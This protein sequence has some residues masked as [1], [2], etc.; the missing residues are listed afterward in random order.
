MNSICKVLPAILVFNIAVW[1]STYYVDFSKGDDTNLGQG[2][3]SAWKHSPGDPNATDKPSQTI[4]N[5]GDTILFKGGVVYRGSIKLKANGVKGKEIV[6]AGDLWGEPPAIIDGSEVIKGWKQCLTEEQAKGNKAYKNLYRCR[7]PKPVTPYSTNIQYGNKFYFVAQY[8]SQPELFYYDNLANYLNQE[9][10]ADEFLVHSYLSSLNEDDLINNYVLTYE[11]N[12]VVKPR[13]ILKFIRNENKIFFEKISGTYYSGEKARF[14]LA[15]CVKFINKE[16]QF[17]FYY[18]S[19]D[20]CELF[21]WPYTEKPDSEHITYSNKRY[22]ISVTGCNHIIVQ[23][24]I[25]EKAA[26]YEMATGIGI[27]TV[28]TTPKISTSN[29]TIKNNIIRNISDASRG[30]YGGIYIGYAR[31]C[32]VDG[33]VITNGFNHRGI[34]FMGDTNCI[35]SNNK[36]IKPGGTGMTIRGSVNCAFIGNK[37]EDVKSGHAN[38]MTCYNSDSCFLINNDIE[39]PNYTMTVQVNKYLVIIG[40]VINAKGGLRCLVIYK[41]VDRAIIYHNTIVE[42]GNNVGIIVPKS[43]TNS[44]IA[45]NI[46]CGIVGIRNMRSEVK[47]EYNCYT[48]T[49]YDQDWKD[50]AGIGEIKPE[51]ADSIFKELSKKGY[52]LDSGDVCVDQGKD[53]TSLLP[54]ADK[55]PYFDFRIDKNGNMRG[56]DGKYDIGAVEFPGVPA[57]SKLKIKPAAGKM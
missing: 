29:I 11:G 49:G 34:L 37:V 5:A 8:P 44:H 38:G 48:A 12:N 14:A 18:E 46:I 21:I 1:A 23:G 25:V 16:G 47:L 7:V 32:L 42:S 28:G 10:M 35:A 30:G 9:Q 45:N 36:V 2:P 50:S 15:N 56:S 33:N 41:D 57:P 22:G 53:L 39:S 43:V 40:N 51:K 19:G 3:S 20:S 27:G 4:L 26:G 17:A 13:K 54:P 31:D 6:I 24:F 52:Q 55:F